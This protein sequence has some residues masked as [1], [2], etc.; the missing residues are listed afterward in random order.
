MVYYFLIEI[1]AKFRLL[2]P[3]EHEEKLIFE[4]ANTK[5]IRRVFT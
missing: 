5:E 1:F 2:W 4:V 3:T